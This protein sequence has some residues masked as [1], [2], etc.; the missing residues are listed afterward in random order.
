VRHLKTTPLFI[1]LQFLRTLTTCCNIWHIVYRVNLQHSSW[2][3]GY[4]SPRLWNPLPDL[5]CQSH[6][7]CLSSPPHPLVITSLSSSSLSSSITPPLFHSRLKIPFQ[8]ILPGLTFL[9]THWTAFMITGMDQTYHA[10]QFIFSFSFAFLFVPCGRLSWLSVSFLLHVKYT[11]SYRIFF[12]T[13]RM[14]CCY[15]TLG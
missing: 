15:T 6:H 9:L 1:I 13:S 8:Q 14:C 11:L 12:T 5:F 2:W 4:A 7:S 3:F 10:R